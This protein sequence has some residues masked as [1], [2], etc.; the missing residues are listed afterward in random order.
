M[1]GKLGWIISAFLGAI[2]VAILAYSLGSQNKQETVNTTV[3]SSTSSVSS[4]VSTS[5]ASSS[6]VVEQQTSSSQVLVQQAPSEDYHTII[7]SVISQYRSDVNAALKTRNG[8]AIVRN[9]TS[10]SNPYYIETAS[11]IT[12]NSYAEGIAMYNSRTTAIRNI[13]PSGDML[14]FS[15]DYQTET[16]YNGSGAPSTN[17]F[18]RDYILRKVNGVWKIEKF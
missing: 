17:N 1:N 10:D 11:W 9:F 5:Q 3:P 16:Y 4:E 8:A 14:S 2:L 6:Q 12:N 18:T 15:L 7:N 13:V